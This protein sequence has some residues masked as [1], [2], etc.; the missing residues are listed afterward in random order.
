MGNS[1]AISQLPFLGSGFFPVRRTVA[2]PVSEKSEIRVCSGLYLSMALTTSAK[3]HSLARNQRRI[4]DPVDGCRLCILPPRN[5]FL[6]QLWTTNYVD[7][8][9]SRRKAIREALASASVDFTVSEAFAHLSHDGAPQPVASASWINK[10]LPDIAASLSKRDL[11][12]VRFVGQVGTIS[13]SQAGRYWWGGQAQ[14][15]RTAQ[16]ALRKLSAQQLLYRVRT[17]GDRQS[18]DK[19]IYFLGVAGAALLNAESET[20]QF[21]AVTH[22]DQVGKPTIN[23]NLALIDD[24]QGL[25]LNRAGLELGGQAVELSMGLANFW[26]THHLAIEAKHVSGSGSYIVP[27]GFGV[28]DIEAEVS[29]R[30]VAMV[31]PFLFELDSGAKLLSDVGLQIA[32]YQG[33]INDLAT[34]K[35]FPQLAVEGYFPPMI[36]A[37]DAAYKNVTGRTDSRVVSSVVAAKKA[38]KEIGIKFEYPVFVC[39]REEIKE[40]GFAAPAF[41]V[42]EAAP[43]RGQLKDQP[44]LLSRLAAASTKL[45]SNRLPENQRIKVGTVLDLDPKGAAVSSWGQSAETAAE[46]KRRLEREEKQAQATADYLESFNASQEGRS[47]E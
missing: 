15:E 30:A 45:N 29:G 12:I 8:A 36:F 44:S 37:T 43:E 9:E 31:L 16:R 22:P 17:V 13:R 24:L 20:S 7:G 35:R 23:H 14:E 28:A 18:Q 33:L 42:A 2:K 4:P 40:K 41:S 25:A 27:D 46:R 19:A 5:P 21:K 3:K 39:S 47:N 26:G 11:E 38:I 32:N 1:E 6:V 34:G 10:Q